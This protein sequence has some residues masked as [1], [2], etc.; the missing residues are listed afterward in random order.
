MC[1]T[2]LV[3]NILIMG[4]KEENMN[5]KLKLKE[6]VVIAMV[7]AL[8]GIVFTLLD[9]LYQPLQVLAGPI[10]GDIINGLYLLSALLPIFIIRK[11]GAALLGSLF[12]GIVNLLLGSPYGIHIIIAAVL[13]GVGAEVVLASFKYKDYKVLPMS[14]AA[15]VASLFVTARDYFVFGF[16]LYANLIPVMIGVRIVSAVIFGALVAIA[17][18][19]GLKL[20]GV[21]NGFNINR[22]SE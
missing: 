2:T 17:L 15:I 13:Q 5:K 7:S 1:Y 10:G 4:G 18:G 11:P 8:I 21:L 22:R 16:Q 12:T 19:N 20:T 9:S 14:L 6:I 3:E